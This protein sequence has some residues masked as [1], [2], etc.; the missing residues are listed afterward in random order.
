MKDLLLYA[1]YVER[2]QATKALNGFF[3][4]LRK[5]PW[6]GQYI[7]VEIFQSYE[8]KKILFV[9][10][11][12]LRIFLGFLLKTFFI[13]GYFVAALAGLNILTGGDNPFAPQA[14]APVVGILWWLLFVG[15]AN[16]FFSGL[17]LAIPASIREIMEN[18][19]LSRR[20]FV[21][22][23][24]LIEPVLTTLFYLPGFLIYSLI[25]DNFLF[26]LIGSTG[27]LAPLLTGA[28]LGRLLYPR[29]TSSTKPIINIALA[30]VPLALMGLAMVFHD[31]LTKG[32]LWGVVGSL[33]ALL[34]A[35]ASYILRHRESEEFLATCFERSLE[36]DKQVQEAKA[37]SNQYTAQGLKMQK[38]LSLDSTKDL[39]HLS[40]M[41][42]LNALLF[43]RYKS[44]L[45]KKIY[46]RLGVILGAPVLIHLIVFLAGERLDIPKEAMMAGLPGLFMV[47]YALSIGK[48]IAQMVFVN[49]DITMLHYPFYRE[50]KQI[51]AGFN[52]RWL[53][54]FLYNG[55]LA[56]ALF[57]AILAIGGYK[58]GMTFQ[59]LLALLLISLT[60]LLSFHDL[61]IYYIL[62]PF[63]KDM[64]VVNPFYKFLS[65]AT[66]WLAYANTQLRVSS[67]LYVLCISLALL[68]YVGIGYL[69]LLK[70]APKTFV[71]KA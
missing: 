2:Y 11:V 21:R 48:P 19:R 37:S 13:A 41:T 71:L 8:A 26:L 9:L 58:A 68:L 5:I 38:K 56:L 35:S 31:Q 60:A 22:S 32:A 69:I 67:A 17:N 62:Q 46:W 47:M 44:I 20:T 65:G 52:Y 63:T 64:E 50:P 53:K 15:V 16:R 25:F 23:Q 18:L 34:L 27:I 54:S 7:P 49:C 1:W 39:S 42:Y 61:F 3:Y 24:L 14:A 10:A 51:I 6:I 55:S 30:S 36:V 33:L 59:L 4:Y 12:C 66:Y 40:G 45:H 70:K 43:E 28:S 57:I 29:K